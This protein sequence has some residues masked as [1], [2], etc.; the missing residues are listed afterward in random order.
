MRDVIFTWSLLIDWLKLID[1][2]DKTVLGHGINSTLSWYI[3]FPYVI[4][5]NLLIFY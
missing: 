3:I 1:F 4:G 2:N 5:F